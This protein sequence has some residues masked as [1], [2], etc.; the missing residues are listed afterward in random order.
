MNKES[1]PVERDIHTVSAFILLPSSFRLLPSEVEI[2]ETAEVAEVVV[3]QEAGISA[4]EV[5]GI[6]VE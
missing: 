1:K 5:A 2:V 4:T 6:D 3:A